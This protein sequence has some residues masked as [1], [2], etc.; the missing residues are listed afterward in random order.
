MGG[1]EGAVRQKA[2]SFLIGPSRRNLQSP[3]LS[4]FDPTSCAVFVSTASCILGSVMG[5][6]CIAGTW[7]NVSLNACGC[8]SKGSEDVQG[9]E[10][11]HGG[12]HPLTDEPVLGTDFY[13]ARLGPTS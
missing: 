8:L 3:P 11:L 6:I 12:R 1:P 4:C 9:T 10:C 2:L 5:C 7:P 13:G